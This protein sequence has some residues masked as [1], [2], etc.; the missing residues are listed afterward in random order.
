MEI[1]S[2]ILPFKLLNTTSPYVHDTGVA[3]TF[4]FDVPASSADV[5]NQLT[6]SVRFPVSYGDLTQTNMTCLMVN[7]TAQLMANSTAQC[8]F[9][10]QNY[11]EIT[12]VQRGSTPRK[13][14][15][16]V[17]NVINPETLANVFVATSYTGYDVGSVICQGQDTLNL[18]ATSPTACQL[19]VDN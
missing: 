6:V 15:M 16:V 14:F 7:S 18:L 13:Y 1:S 5:Q 9:S 11:I 2:C 8:S 4:Q 12:G 17:G 19:Q 3:Y 10:R